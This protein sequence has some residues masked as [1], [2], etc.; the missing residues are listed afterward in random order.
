MCA[1]RRDF[2]RKTLNALAKRNINVIGS[3]A[4]P[5]YEGDWSLS[6]RVYQLSVDGCSIMR[7]LAQVEEMAR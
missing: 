3:Q 4:A 2:S 5:A 6:G 1:A 7:S